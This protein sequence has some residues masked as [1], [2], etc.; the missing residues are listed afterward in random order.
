MKITKVKTF[1]RKMLTFWRMQ[2]EANQLFDF[3]RREE[4]D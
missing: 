1:R 2:V 4:R 3:F